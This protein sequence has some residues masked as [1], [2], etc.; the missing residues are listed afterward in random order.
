MMPTR[1]ARARS[2]LPL[3]GLLLGTGLATPAPSTA[4]GR[5]S[6]EPAPGRRA[7][8][9]EG[10]YDR[11]V[12]RG[13][14]VI[15]GT[16]APPRGPVDV[17]I[18]G[19]RIA[20]IR[21]TTDPSNPDSRPETSVPGTRILDAT[22]MYVLPGLIDMHAHLGGVPQGT[23]ADYV[24]KLWMGH[25]IT[26]IRDPGSGD[27]LEFMLD[28]RT[29]SAANEIVAP[30][31]FAYAI[32]GLGWDRPITT[33][34]EA[35]EWVRWVASQGVDGV[36][37][38]DTYDP[39][40]AAAVFDEA[41]KQGL[42]SA[43]HLTQVGVARMDALD[44]ARAG[45]STLE[46]WYGLPEAL[47]DDRTVQDFPYDYD[48]NNEYD[49]FATA[50][51]LWAQAAPPGSARREAVIQELLDL[52][53]MLVPTFTIYE[54]NRDVMRARNA[55]WHERY[56]LPSLW[57]FYQP[58]P[59]SH[60]SY[61]FHWTTAD[62]I[63]WKEN[64]RL[65]M[66]F[67]NEYKNRGGKVGAGSDAGFIYKLYGFAY[68]RELELLQEAGFHPLEVIRSATMV[69]AQELYETKGEPPPFGVIQ[70]GK[71]ADLVVVEENP[72]EDL[73]VLYG[74][75]TI[76]LDEETHEV[77]RVGGVKWTIKDGIVYDARR[78][79]EDVA[80]M[81]EQAKAAAATTDAP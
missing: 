67:V 9:G 62:E 16:G 70:P 73:K 72:I 32:V 71:L 53:F 50:G 24:L 22:G 66:D 81:V 8:E 37:L 14:T 52:D 56:T 35:R 6:I 69:G 21:G 78:L 45:L 57:D 65:W 7:D 11:L 40:I 42:G 23:P 74:T 75:G 48:Y 33:P 25:G 80:R 55:D 31:I 43:A 27:G 41:K 51:R 60:G 3:A 30:R 64:F 15:D 59:R 29:R 54:A 12:L 47:F 49:R 76:R 10:P 17:V 68:I 63:A 34:E 5:G 44:A 26:T 36:K 4:Q 18:E 79:L 58:N 38:R 39:D 61:W 28:H 1:L 46:H 77:R 20:A 2:L 13:V 19:N